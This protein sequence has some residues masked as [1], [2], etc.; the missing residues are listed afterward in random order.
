M[1]DDRTDLEVRTDLGLS[2]DLLAAFG[3]S[4]LGHAVLRVLSTSDLEAEMPIAA[5]QDSL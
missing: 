4:A 2:T 3:D 1:S 5:F